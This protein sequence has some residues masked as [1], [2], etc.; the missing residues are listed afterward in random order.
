MF[1]K[2][3]NMARSKPNKTF[4]SQHKQ[5]IE[6]QNKQNKTDTTTNVTPHATKTNKRKTGTDDRSEKINVTQ[7]KNI[8]NPEKIL[9]YKGDW[10]DRRININDRNKEQFDEAGYVV[11]SSGDCF[12]QPS[13]EYPQGNFLTEE[14]QAI[15]KMNDSH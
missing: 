5:K 9:Y 7:N 8:P 12:M 15:I 6:E 2:S 14:E 4:K 13:D 1:F 10:L 3:T 11:N